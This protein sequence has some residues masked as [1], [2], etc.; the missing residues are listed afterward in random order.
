[1][2]FV[3]VETVS[4]KKVPVV[5]RACWLTTVSWLNETAKFMHSKNE[6]FTLEQHKIMAELTKPAWKDENGKYFAQRED[7]WKQAL[8]WAVGEKL[9]TLPGDPKTYFTNAYVPDL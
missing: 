9:I 5:A 1:M 7:V 8:D 3:P 2:T 6:I 4:V